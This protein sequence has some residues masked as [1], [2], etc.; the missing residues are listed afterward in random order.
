MTF[1]CVRDVKRMRKRG[2]DLEKLKAVVR[3]LGAAA[4]PEARHRNHALAGPWKGARDCHVEPD[5]VLI[6]T[7]GE[8]FLRLER[9]GT[10]ADLLE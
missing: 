8:D 2:K 4:A 1:A 6:Y 5:W 9:T 10:N 7:A 3:R